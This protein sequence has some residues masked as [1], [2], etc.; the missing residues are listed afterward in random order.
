[1][2]DCGHEIIEDESVESLLT[3]APSRKSSSKSQKKLAVKK[4]AVLAALPEIQILVSVLFDSI[5]IDHEI[6]LR[7]LSSSSSDTTSDSTSGAAAWARSQLILSR[8]NGDE[9]TWRSDVN[10]VI[11]SPVSV[12]GDHGGLGIEQAETIVCLDEDWSGRE[13]LLLRS[14]V[15][16][17]QLQREATGKT[18]AA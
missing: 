16:R 11:A 17:C 2:K 3:E 8:F 15:A 12:A 13:E 6:L 18:A 1:M 9:S 10:V 14:L 7:P 5:G 4:V